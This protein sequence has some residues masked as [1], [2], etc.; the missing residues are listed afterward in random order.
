MPGWLPLHAQA[1]SARGLLS[2]GGEG[3]HEP[4]IPSALV[5]AHSP[6]EGASGVMGRMQGGRGG[7]VDAW[8]VRSLP[9]TAQ[10]A[11]NK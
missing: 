8:I 9:D 1:I 10:V 3:V 7:G 5:I 6:Q 4:S 2:P 11:Y